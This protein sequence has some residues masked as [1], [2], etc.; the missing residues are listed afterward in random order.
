MASLYDL[1]GMVKVTL[2]HLGGKMVC[3]MVETSDH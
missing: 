2:N 3:W 1:F